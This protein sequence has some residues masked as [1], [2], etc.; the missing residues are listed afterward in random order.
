MTVRKNPAASG[1]GTRI[2]VLGGGYTGLMT[3][4]RVARRTRRQGGQVTLL[5]P[6][7]RFVERLRLHQLA[8]GQELADL[9]IPRLLAGTGVT[10][11][12]GAAVRIDRAAH[13]VDVEGPDGPGQLGYDLLVYALGSAADLGS[14]PGAADHAYTLNGP[15]AAGRLADRLAELALPGEDVTVGAETPAGA[16]TPPGQATSAGRVAIVGAGLTGIEMAAEIAE[17]FPALR[18][19]LL[20]RDQPGLMMGAAARAYLYRALDR[21]GIE[22]RAGVD[23]TKV[24]PGAVEVDGDLAPMAADAVVWTTGFRAPALAAEA[25]LAVDGHG[26]VVVDQALRSETDPAVYVIGD[27]AAVRQPWG[28]LH[29]SCQSGLPTAAHAADS[30]GRQLRGR[31]PRPFR[32][33]YIH[34][35]VSL[36]RRDAV[37]QFT[38]GDDSPRRWYLKGRAAVT[39]K[40]L[41]SGSPPW[42]YRLSRWFSAPMAMLAP[43][44]GPRWARRG[45]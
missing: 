19:V 5:N 31:A 30:I 13:T 4:V 17:T 34:Q 36:G 21:L 28:T 3:A 2:L 16:E 11:V 23:V 41:V 20:S 25:G 29:G 10:F 37:I 33:G 6:S 45:R 39:Y 7:D 24:L 15:A 22:V 32:F 18:V 9:R 38:H 12:R 42:T 35:P 1:G 43:G 14:V 26:R 8:T 40:E 44:T 27:A